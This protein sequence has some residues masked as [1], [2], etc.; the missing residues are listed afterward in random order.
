MPEFS[1]RC[2]LSAPVRRVGT[3]SERRYKLTVERVLNA[4]SGYRCGDAHR[5]DS[6]SAAGYPEIRL[7]RERTS[8]VGKRNQERRRAKKKERDARQRSRTSADSR[9]DFD[10]DGPYWP[11]PSGAGPF[12]DRPGRLPPP[13]PAPL[14]EILETMLLGVLSAP[15][16]AAETA[17]GLSAGALAESPPSGTLGWPAMSRALVGLAERM[18]RGCWEGGWQPAE[19]VRLTGR[20]LSAR[21]IRL[22]V[23]LVAA[24]AR[25]Y[26]A[27]NL[28][29]RWSAQ[30]GELAATVWWDDDGSF[31]DAL[32]DREGLDRLGVATCALELL[33]LLGTVPRIPPVGPKPD[34]DHRTPRQPAPRTD[35]ESRMLHRIR[36][37][38]AKAESTE[39]PEEAE[40]FTS[41]AQQL[42]AQHSIS[43]ALL[44]A[45]AGSRD[46]PAARRIGIDNPY[47]A[48]KALLLDAVTAANRCRTVWSRSL[49]FSTVVGY[50]PDL[51]A[52]EL[53]YTSLLVQATT[54]MNR[55]GSRRDR[56]GRSRTRTFRQSFLVAYASRISERLMTATEQ[57]TSDA[58]AGA[59]PD[60]PEGADATVG[61]GLPPVSGAADQRLLPVLAA[62]ADA[63][64]DA[65]DRMFPGVTA[66]A[67]SGNDA[68]GWAHG[69]AAADRARLHGHAEVNSRE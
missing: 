61:L 37:L 31:L 8:K 16:E 45:G 52:V 7:S 62:R 56:H 14:A 43:A 49:G 51:D 50:E 30:L 35:A 1:Y 25:R 48:P 47:E 29:P 28:D 53:L 9:A 46:E 40:A 41:K 12:A 57:A 18:V 19:L 20:E 67:L 60:G 4:E 64:N 11:G 68:E 36:A 17:I 59:V 33:R 65:T 13:R 54:A 34:S 21:H 55:A 24:E 63:V 44:A 10:G 6:A 32:G 39:Y 58:V 69:T 38:L 3:T 26:S 27:A 42:M 23:D 2:C 15:D 66:H 22:A 5:E